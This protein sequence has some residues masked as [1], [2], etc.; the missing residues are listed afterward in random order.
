MKLSDTLKAQRAGHLDAMEALNKAAGAEA[1]GGS[2]R[3]FTAD[4]TAGWN[5]AKA[6]VA[7]LD[8]RITQAV[9]REEQARGASGAPVLLGD[10]G[11]PLTVLRSGDKLAD[12]HRASRA[13]GKDQMD[14]FTPGAVVRGLVTGQWDGRDGLQRALSSLTPAAG[15][16]T[17]PTEL[18]AVWLDLARA[19]SVCNAAG[20]ITIPMETQTLRIA[21][22]AGDVVPVFRKELQTIGNSNATFRAVDL[23]ARSIAVITEVTLELLA[24]SPNAATMLEHSMLTAMGQAMDKALLSGDGDTTGSLDN[25]LGILNWAGIG[26]TA[27]VGTPVDYAPWLAAMGGIATANHIPATIV[28]T[29]ATA[30][31]LAALP[32][33]ITGDKTPL[34][35]PKPYADA[36]KLQT[37]GIGDGNSLAGDFTR[38]G[39]GLRESVVI[40]ATRLS[41]DAFNR[42][43]VRVRAMM[44]YDTF[45]THAAAFWAL[46]GI[47]Y[48]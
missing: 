26:S 5:T 14:E 22:L 41:D 4:E 20:A 9:E 10:N 12:R 36:A 47:T 48:A 8:A 44:R 18:S 7:T 31:H 3:E 2:P 13:I 16:Y 11:K 25:P 17:V 35:P 46:K 39:W 42:A 28:D 45:V 19:A 37:T 6:A 24:D 34:L 29:P 27:A 1:N 38:S 40:E 43:Q 21:G 23:R 30:Y 15:G 33:G 32:T